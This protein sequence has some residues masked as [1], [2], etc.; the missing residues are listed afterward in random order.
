MF[1][2]SASSFGGP[3]G[4]F[5][6]SSSG[7]GYPGAHSSFSSMG[8]AAASNLPFLVKILVRRGAVSNL[9]QGSGQLT[10][11]NDATGVHVVA[12]GQHFD[13]NDLTGPYVVTNEDG[14]LVRREYTP[15]DAEFEER[16]REQM[17]DSW[18]RMDDNFAANWKPFA[19]MKPMAPMQPFRMRSLF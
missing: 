7:S 3:G 18:N 10:F 14:P 8:S 1:Q 17:R 6:S 13:S 4:I 16:Q 15:E 2:Q 12:N 9:S 5:S 11:F 19:P